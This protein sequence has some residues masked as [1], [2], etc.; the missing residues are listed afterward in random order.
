MLEKLS[1]LLDSGTLEGVASV[2]SQFNI[3]DAVG[4]ANQEIRHSTFL[5]FL[6]NPSETHGLK[7][8]FLRGFLHAVFK[9]EKT[10]CDH[11]A[12]SL[13][14]ARV[15]REWNH[16]DL[17]V[18]LPK[19][20][21]V[22]VIENKVW[23]G[24]H[25]DQLK[26]YYEIAQAHHVGW[27][28]IPVYLT[29]GG[30]APS[31]PRYK[32]VRYSTVVELIEELLSAPRFAGVNNDTC[33]LLRHYVQLIRRNIVGGS[34]LEALCQ[35][36]YL[37]HREAIDLINKYRPDTQNDLRQL[38]EELVGETGDVLP[39]TPIKSK[40]ASQNQLYCLFIPTAWDALV[41]DTAEDGTNWTK[42]ICHFTIANLPSEM[43]VKLELRPG[44]ERDRQRFY[45][46][47]QS[48]GLVSASRLAKFPE[49]GR[50][51]LL[52]PADYRTTTPAA[53]QE[54]V[55]SGWN[56]FVENELPRIT[57]LFQKELQEPLS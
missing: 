19:E 53:L 48:A 35:K 40:S 43:Y 49:L 7:D 20:R 31:D 21:V 24:E 34:E 28:I 55:R 17:L 27:Q 25:S 16:I 57:D 4:M 39:L 9:D 51:P 50:W 10:A 2:A 18:R 42:R 38:I 30:A 54:I 15:S 47:A 26:R 56:D 11:T 6:L 41:P 32:A 3:F 46:I 52:S 23:T 33:V 1:R 45:R 14:D 44:S 13:E 36:V 29:P 12:W 5:S 8:A 37:E 22:L